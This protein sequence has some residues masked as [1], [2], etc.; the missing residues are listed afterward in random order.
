MSY[1]PSTSYNPGFPLAWEGLDYESAK[2]ATPRWYGV[3]SG[4]G[5]NGV[6]HTWP[7]YYVRTADPFTV[8]AAAMIARFTE[9][10]GQAWAASNCGV[11]GES[12]YT[13]YAVI[14]DPPDDNPERDHSECE[15]GEDCEGCDMCFPDHDDSYSS[16]NGAWQIIEVFP[17]EDMEE[18][19]SSAWRYDS[20]REA[21]TRKVWTLAQSV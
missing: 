13:I 7:D 4:N 5:N 8:A 9:G 15:D 11:V 10:E 16:A 17:V 1:T 14:Y 2:D 12:D 18:E 21:F 6:S 3:S 19:R 20:D